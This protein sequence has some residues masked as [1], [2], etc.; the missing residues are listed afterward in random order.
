MDTKLVRAGLAS[1]GA[2][3]GY[4]LDAPG[5]AVGATAIGVV[6][7]MFASAVG[8]WDIATS[9][10]FATAGIATGGILRGVLGP[11][12]AQEPITRLLRLRSA[13]HPSQDGPNTLVHI[14]RGF[15]PSA[16]FDL[17]FYFRGWNSCVPVIAGSAPARC[18]PDGRERQHSDVVGQL[19]RANRPQTVLIMPEWTIEAA[20]SDP[21]ALA[22]EGAFRALAEEVLTEVVSPAVGAPV[23]LLG[24]RGTILASHSGGYNPT[25]VAMDRGGLPPVTDI[26]LLDA[27]Y[28]G[29]ASFVRF[30]R[31]GGRLVSIFTGGQTQDHSVS[32][33]R[34]VG[35]VVDM[36]TSMPTAEQWALPMLAKKTSSSHSTVPLR[37][38]QPWLASR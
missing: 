17:F 22:R 29:D 20:T 10:G 2:I 35:G 15:D 36:D 37:Y 18:R 12:L 26:L 7:A 14:P 16:P 30:V 8:R 19:D 1:G 28:G 31:G 25:Q 23:S 34:S 32:V 38:L 9:V 6:G 33:A 11:R 21:G 13:A 3:L 27:L 5:I 4:S 24:A